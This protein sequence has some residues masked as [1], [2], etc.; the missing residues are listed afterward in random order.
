MAATGLQVLH[1]KV[2]GF[3]LV[4]LLVVVAIVA[5]IGAGVAVF[6]G[7]EAVD[8]A[9]RQMT[10]H[11]MSQIR[12]AFQRFYADNIFQ[13]DGG[14]SV[15]GTSEM[16][17]TAR[18][19]NTL[20]YAARPDVGSAVQFDRHYAAM[21]FFERFGLWF[22]LRP[23]AAARGGHRP[24]EFIVFD[25]PSLIT[26]HGWRGPYVAAQNV[27][28]CGAD[29]GMMPRPDDSGDF[30]FPQPATKFGGF[31]QVLYYEHC[32]DD[33]MAGAA[34]VRRLLL[35]AAANPADYDEWDEVKKLTGNRRQ[36]SSYPVDPV[37]GAVE[38]FS[39][40]NGLFFVELANFDKTIGR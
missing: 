38:T 4:E 12:D 33:S 6:Y 30:R 15:P 39:S 34:V 2:K 27:I 9:K 7:R 20:D 21:E 10:L 3:T 18:F 14:V 11:E 25:R 1:M 40:S 32:A 29:G 26:G 31:Y 28:D 23:S 36:G 35:M 5:V 24:D 16:L 37:T 17:P 8:D 19:V 13:I 22:L